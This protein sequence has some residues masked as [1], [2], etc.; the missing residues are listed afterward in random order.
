MHLLDAMRRLVRGGK[1][2]ANNVSS[3]GRV[4][5][6]Q[7]GVFIDWPVAAGD[8]ANLLARDNFAGIPKDPDTLADL[9]VS[10][11]LL[12]NNQRGG[13]YWTIALPGTFEAKDG[14]VKLRDGN[15]IFPQGF[16]FDPYR[17]VQLTLNAASPSAASAASSPPHQH[18]PK[19]ASQP[20]PMKEQ[21]S[22]APTKP[23]GNLSGAASAATHHGNAPSVK[24]AEEHVSVTPPTSKKEQTEPEKKAGQS[25]SSEHPSTASAPDRQPKK[26]K[27]QQPKPQ[28]PA[29][30]EGAGEDE[31][32]NPAPPGIESSVGEGE[33]LGAETGPTA[34][35]LLGS[36]KKGNAWLLNE[37][38]NAYPVLCGQRDR[39]P[40]HAR[41]SAVF[42]QHA[43]SELGS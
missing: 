35:K 14:M 18:S 29:E 19:P 15:V 27:R 23:T 34:V 9:L 10:A 12:Q 8:I 20:A 39:R 7:E 1:W 30:P 22:A 16:D 21:T 28:S 42:R 43:R 32:E 33:D 3:G 26:P 41:H 37:V 6:G 5:V 17:N 2:I 36:L 25:A 13:R 4:W 31:S 24:T 11:N 38:M 40:P